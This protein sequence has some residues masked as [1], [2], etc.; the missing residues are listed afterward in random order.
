M[1]PKQV[2]S[3]HLAV[4]AALL[5]SQCNMCEEIFH[6]LGVQGVEVLIFLN[7]LF[8]PVVAPVSQQGFGVTEIML[9]ASAP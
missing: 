1:S 3:W 7:A 8:L 9:S 6:V 2:W 5:F 4:V